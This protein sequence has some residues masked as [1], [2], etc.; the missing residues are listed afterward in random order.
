MTDRFEPMSNID[1]SFEIDKSNEAVKNIAPFFKAI[2]LL[3][4]NGVIKDEDSNF[5]RDIEFEKL[6]TDPNFDPNNLTESEIIKLGEYMNYMQS[7]L[8]DDNEE[9]LA[10]A[11][12]AA[13]KL[14]KKKKR[15]RDI[16]KH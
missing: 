6:L 16:K 7:I 13:S 9:S 5:K 15:W 3:R 12:N 10:R 1:E 14:K 11:V 8:L 2:S 4:D